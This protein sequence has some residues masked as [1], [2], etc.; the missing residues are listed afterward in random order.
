MRVPAL[1]ACVNVAGS[2][3]LSNE[4]RDL[5]VLQRL[6]LTYGTRMPA[7][8]LYLLLLERIPTTRDICRRANPPRSVWWDPCGERNEKEGGN[9]HYE[10]GRAALMQLLAKAPAEGG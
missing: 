6:G 3:G 7:R 1:K 9:P 4:K 8:Q 5:D 2:G 10:Q